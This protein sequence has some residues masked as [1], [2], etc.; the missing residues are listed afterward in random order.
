[1]LLAQIIFSFF[2]IFAIS[3]TIIRFK[4]KEIFLAWFLF[5]IIFWSAVIVAVLLPW[6]TTVLAEWVGIGRGVDLV[7]YL[8]ITCLFYLIFRLFVR[9]EQIERNIT[10][11]VEKNAIREFKKQEYVTKDSDSNSKL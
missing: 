4:K 8:S 11:L 3:R 6:T 10:K 5:W 9:I 1:M 2:A 7:I